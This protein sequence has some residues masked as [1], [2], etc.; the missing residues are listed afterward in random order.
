MDV[1]ER[2]HASQRRYAA[3]NAGLG[4]ASS[5]QLRTT[6]GGRSDIHLLTVAVAEIS[7]AADE[8]DFLV[9]QPGDR[10]LALA[11]AG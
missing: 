2:R 4:G 1:G 11:L 6:I 9:G 8:V 3:D 7:L 10:L 5:P